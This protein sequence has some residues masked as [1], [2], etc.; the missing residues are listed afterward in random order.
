MRREEYTFHRKN[1]SLFVVLFRWPEKVDFR[2]LI[3][4][5]LSLCTFYTSLGENREVWLL[6][7]TYSLAPFHP[8]VHSEGDGTFG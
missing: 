6:G 3:E 2:S 4:H 8:L 1:I 7:L 5:S